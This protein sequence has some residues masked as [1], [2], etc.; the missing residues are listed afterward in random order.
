[1]KAL[2]S[3]ILIILL[4]AFAEYFCA[5]WM[6]AVVAFLVALII[7]TPKSFLVGFLSIFIFWFFAALIK[8]IPN[9]HILS[10]KMAGVL[11]LHGNYILFLI[12]TGLV[13]GLV[14][15]V[16]AWS[17]TMFRRLLVNK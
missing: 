2:L 6:I 17:G 11:P 16:A 14:G 3:F 5:W 1:M 4:S 12:V 7:R 9:N 10:T 13:G 8:D 15:G